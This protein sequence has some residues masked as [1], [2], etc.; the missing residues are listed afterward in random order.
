MFL[1]FK[2]GLSMYIIVF[3]GVSKINV[4]QLFNITCSWGYGAVCIGIEHNSV[5]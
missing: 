2:D 1:L 5:I 4:H 3:R